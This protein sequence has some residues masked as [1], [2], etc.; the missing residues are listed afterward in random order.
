M[1]ER[2]QMSKQRTKLITRRSK[3]IVLASCY[4]VLF[5]ILSYLLD[6]Y[7]AWW[8]NYFKRTFSDLI[9]ELFISLIFCTVVASGSIYIHEKLNRFI[10]WIE[11]PRKRL[12]V[13]AL[14]NMVFVIILIVVQILIIY[15]GIGDSTE[16]ENCENLDSGFFQWI[17]IS[18]IIALII[19]AINTGDYLITNWKNADLEITEHKLKSAQDKQA[20]AEAELQAL[21]LQ[22]DP[23]FV[24][25][26]LSVLSELILQDQQLGY[27][28]A[29]NF[30][31]VYRYLLL[32]S[33]RN[34]ISLEDEL[35]FLRAYI[36]LLEKR[37]GEGLAFEIDID[38]SLLSL[39]LP[40]L[41]LQLLIENAIKHNK[42]IKTNPLMISIKSGADK[43]LIISNVVIPLEKPSVFSSGIGLNNIKQRYELL[44][45]K[46]PVIKQTQNKF[47][48]TI[49]LI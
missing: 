34:L 4:F 30:S 32:N 19:S 48:V 18:V 12:A 16:C 7:S 29:E 28:Y 11:K 38:N 5:Y 13:E 45:A 47:I 42:I 17:T 49:P 46:L 43:E 23:H 3:T 26:N 22:L 40:P 24:F 37:A 20:V 2:S 41:T 1:P 15:I 35:K 6:P 36:F 25:N 14:L 44:N 21:R 8:Q 39:Q 33:R 10:P 9:T 31:K 27:H